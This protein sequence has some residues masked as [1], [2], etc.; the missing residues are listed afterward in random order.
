[1]QQAME[2]PPSFSSGAVLKMSPLSYLHIKL[3]Y[4]SITWQFIICISYVSFLKYSGMY[5]C[6]LIYL[7]I[8]HTTTILNS[9]AGSPGGVGEQ[10]C[11]G[12]AF[13]DAITS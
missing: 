12:E 4:H 2:Y 10:A 5:T 11:V 6:P 8:P 3:N 9:I 7:P 1:M 13:R